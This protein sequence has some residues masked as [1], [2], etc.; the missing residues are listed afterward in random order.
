MDL[1]FYFQIADKAVDKVSKYLLLEFGAIK[2][3]TIKGPSD[4]QVKEDLEANKIY[5]KFLKKETPD[6]LLFTEEG[7]R[8]LSDG[9]VWVVDPIEGTSNYRVGIPFFATTICL[10]HKK[11]PLL[12]VV[13]APALKQKFHAIKGKGAFLNSKK[14]KRSNQKDLEN[15]MIAVGRGRK[16]EDKI[17]YSKTIVSLLAKVRTSRTLGSAGLDMAYTAAGMLD[18]YLSRGLEAG[19]GIYD[20]FPGLLL[21][22]ESGCEVVNEKDKNFKL[23]DRL[24]LAA[25]ETLVKKVLGVI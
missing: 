15:A 13:G 25:N 17:W 8:Q 22:Q 16:Q 24:L 21:L 23:G 9:L 7:M 14:V 5:E 12:S 11:E 19:G 10:I 20:I 6:V 2:K 3:F 1:N 18:V 4:I